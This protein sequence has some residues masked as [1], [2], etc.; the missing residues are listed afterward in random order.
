MKTTLMVL[1][2]CWI[3]SGY[4]QEIPPKSVVQEKAGSQDDKTKTSTNKGSVDA[5][6]P[7]T[8]ILIE[9]A[10]NSPAPNENEKP[11][12]KKERADAELTSF[13]ATHANAWLAAILAVIGLGQFLMFRRQLGIMQKQLDADAPKVF[14]EHIVY[15]YE[16]T[17]T[18]LD[19]RQVVVDVSF[20]NCKGSP[21]VLP[22][23]NYKTIL[24]KNIPV[25]K[26]E[27]FNFSGAEGQDLSYTIF[28]GETKN[29][30]VIIGLGIKSDDDPDFLLVME[31][32]YE[33]MFG[34][35]WFVREVKEM[36]YRT[37]KS[38]RYGGRSYNYTGEKNARPKHWHWQWPLVHI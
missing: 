15:E 17:M 19:G 29:E 27:I 11:E 26:D 1:L 38:V 30:E 31:L 2:V 32:V 22:R 3:S 20:V 13:K 21:A 10:A 9:G 24:T 18:N 25:G 14:F 5:F 4:C 37:P 7:A 28:P 34:R 12:S 36:L 8:I 6:P 35:Q 16:M 33:D 23:L